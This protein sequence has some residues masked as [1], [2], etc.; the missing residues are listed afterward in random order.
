MLLLGAPL[1]LAACSRGKPRPV[2][3]R[4]VGGRIE[5]GHRIRD[6]IDVRSLQEADAVPVVIVGGGMAGLTAAWR[7]S[8]HGHEQYAVFELEGRAGG[9]ST[10]GNDGSVKYP[11]AAHY[12]PVPSEKHESLCA[13][14]NEMGVVERDRDGNL[15]GR[16]G[17]LVR[18]PEERLF[19]DGRWI[20]GLSPLPLMS[21]ADQAEHRRFEAI[22][23]RWASYRDGLGRRAFALP[24]AHCSDASEVMALDKVSARFWLE[25][26]GFKS[27]TLYW[28]LEYGCRD[29]YGTD[30]DTTSAWALLFYHAARIPSAGAESAPFLT[31]PEGNGRVV[32]H[33]EK[34]V[35]GR[36]Q[37]DKL[38]IDVFPEATGARVIVLDV[39]T[40]RL[41]TV[42][43]KQVI[44]ATP[45]FITKRLFRPFREHAPD[46]LSAFSYSPWLVANLHLKGRPK[47]KGFPLA[48][49][50]VIHGGASLGY[51]V[52]SHQTLQDDGP[53]VW[54]YYQ[55][56]VD[57]DPAIA[58]HRLEAAQHDAAWDAVVAEL[59]GAHPDLDQHVTRMD[60]WRWGHAMV[61]P[62][63][64]LISSA[65]RH[66]ACEP[67][68]CF[69]FAHTALS[70]LSLLD[71]AH[72]H[73]VRAAD[74]VLS[75]L[76]QG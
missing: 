57:R 70:G 43:A 46:F 59:S 48:W 25:S 8:R 14:L 15:V 2:A 28:V 7:L 50:N 60:V 51:V 6:A 22:V 42:K 41:S 10:Y 62:V 76:R 72:Y 54:T 69:H 63:P 17:D 74:A 33:L 37:C 1:G 27:R 32:R 26:E 3:G 40:E 58:R 61:R 71:E 47:S 44:F 55:P 45:T 21:A 66:K 52:A 34:V 53:T 64:G 9:T 13:L 36:L 65:A 24:L 56:F 5:V 31:W 38:V 29:D 35:G 18:A 20:E 49:D 67:I 73:G 23:G 4:V 12:L 19:V 68:G 75:Q 39:R 11:W 16:E 30:L